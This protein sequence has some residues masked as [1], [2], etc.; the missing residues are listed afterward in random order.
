MTERASQLREIFLRVAPQVRTFTER[1]Q[2]PRGTVHSERE[3]DERIA[4]LISEMR[5]RFGFRTSL[6][7]DELVALVRGYHADDS[8][9]EI[10]RK[11]DA[12]PAVVARARIN[13]HLF[14]AA[15]E[16]AAFDVDD[17]ARLLDRGRS[18]GACARELGVSEATV[19]R[20]RHPV[21]KRREAQRANH[22]YQT[23]FENAL[24]E[25]DLGEDLGTSL[26]RDRRT[27]DEVRE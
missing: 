6:A 24:A 9:A 5:E 1:Q 11:L 17:L 2:T 25:G 8:D 4:T 7:D 16:P 10:A 26:R 13:L 12:S 14:R 18:V 15:D 23:E 3:I 27:M 22:Y 19:R 20:Y 21:E